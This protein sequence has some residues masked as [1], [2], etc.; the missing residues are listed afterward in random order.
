[1]IGDYVDVQL[2]NGGWYEAQ[3]IKITASETNTEYFGD[4]FDL[5]FTVKESMLII[6]KN[7]MTSKKENANIV[8]AVYAVEKKTGNPL[9]YAMSVMTV[10]ILPV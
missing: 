7:V 1:M 8:P 2:D 5:I 3:I 6:V 9:S 4:E 10:I